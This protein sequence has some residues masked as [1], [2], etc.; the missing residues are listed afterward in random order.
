MLY[1]KV[2]HL[3]FT[4]QPEHIHYFNIGI[5]DSKESAGNAVDIL[6]T[7]DGFCQHPDKFYILKVFRFKNPKFL[8]R[9]F[10]IDGFTTYTYTKQEKGK[11]KMK[12]TIETQITLITPKG[13]TKVPLHIS[14]DNSE[15]IATPETKINLIYNN[16]TYQG[17]G[18]DY[19]WVDVFADLQKKLPENVKLACCMTCQHGNMCPFGNKPNELFCTKNIA[20]N[21]KTDVCDLFSN[22]DFFE[23]AVSYCDYC[24]N[25]AYQNENVY[26]YNDYLYYLSEK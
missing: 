14:Y 5:Y 21:N 3:F 26:T 18:N 13:I 24:D 16:I 11:P 23:N 4:K 6:K 25:F 20:V 9:T 22:H 15:D 2:I 10:W 12:S 17:K 19:L 8:N 7:K 1:Y